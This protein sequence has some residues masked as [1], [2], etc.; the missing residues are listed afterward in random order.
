MSDKC[1]HKAKIKACIL[2]IIVMRRSCIIEKKK[3]W[4]K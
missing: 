2:R 3:K 4:A 1:K